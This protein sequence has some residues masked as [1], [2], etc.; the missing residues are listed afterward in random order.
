MSGVRAISGA[1]AIRTVEKG[2]ITV[3]QVKIPDQSDVLQ[4][5]LNG[6]ATR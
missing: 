5:L 1:E 2:P 3:L 4:I 6:R